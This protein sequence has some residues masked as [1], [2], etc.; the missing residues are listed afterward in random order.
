MLIMPT[1]V[2]NLF[3]AQSAAKTATE[4][5]VMIVLMLTAAAVAL[6]GA[7]IVASLRNLRGTTLLAPALW[8]LA[9]LAVLVAFQAMLLRVP[10][11]RMTREKLDLL[12]ATS[13]FCPLV[14][15]LGAKR[16]QNRPWFWIVL[17][18]WG[19]AALP[20]VE[21]LIVQPDDWIEVHPLWQWFYA[22][23]VVIGCANYLPTRF[24]APAMLAAFGQCA[25]LCDFLPGGSNWL[26]PLRSAVARNILPEVLLNGRR[27]F[28]LW[29]ITAGIVPLAAAV[30]WA[31]LITAKRRKLLPTAVANW[32]RAWLD[33]RN[34]YGVVWGM[35]VI[36][37]LNVLSF[38]T[39]ATLRLTWRGFVPI[40]SVTAKANP[41][42]Q[43]SNLTTAPVD[44]DLPEQIER[45]FRMLLLRF[46][47]NDWIGRR[48]PASSISDASARP[49]IQ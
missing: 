22:I 17:S 37:R 31:Y 40:E 27:D 21:S 20:V 39:G 12:A 48:L 46:V 18:L 34:A 32:N 2:V 6:A 45:D 19:V 10:T 35:R 25:L 3:A 47:S 15:L 5:A 28:R 41:P 42:E 23:L 9:S 49:S 4:I 29:E 8:A 43:N 38:G 44:G 7:A 14:A 11:D 16:P 30:C 26:A 36:E 1:A 24:W 33:F 13:T